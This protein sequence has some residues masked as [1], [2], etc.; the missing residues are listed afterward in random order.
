MGRVKV[1]AGD[2]ENMTFVNGSLNSVGDG[3]GTAIHP[4]NA[5][6]AYCVAVCVGC[7]DRVVDRIHADGAD[8]LGIDAAFG[9]EIIYNAG[10][11][12]YI[13]RYLGLCPVGVRG[14]VVVRMGRFGDYLAVRV[15]E[16]ALEGLGAKVDAYYIFAH[17]I[18]LNFVR[19]QNRVKHDAAIDI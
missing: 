7:D 15:D 2:I 16:E 13:V 11:G 1:K 10:E 5:K 14:G 9:D 17:F 3:L 12:N 6:V 4:D 18:L 19:V 8:I